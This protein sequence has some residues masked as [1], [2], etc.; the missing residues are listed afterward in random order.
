MSIVATR[1]MCTSMNLVA[2]V[3]PIV[4]VTSHSVQLSLFCP[5]CCA[6]RNGEG[7]QCVIGL[8]FEFRIID[9]AINLLTQKRAVVR[10]RQG[11]LGKSVEGPSQEFLEGGGDIVDGRGGCGCS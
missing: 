5:A 2:R 4:K 7:E 10:G 8:L 9:R 11:S 6:A 3:R 1:P